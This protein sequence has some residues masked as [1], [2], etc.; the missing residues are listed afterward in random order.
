M[1]SSEQSSVLQACRRI[2][3]DTK[4]HDVCFTCSDGKRIGCNR[5]FVAASCEYFEKMLIDFNPVQ[6]GLIGEQQAVADIRLQAPSAA[7]SHVLHFLHTGSFASLASCAGDEDQEQHWLSLLETC[8]L[9]QLYMLPA[10]QQHIAE[11]L[12]QELPPHRLGL[13][14]SFAL[15]VRLACEQWH[16][17]SSRCNQ[18]YEGTH[19]MSCVSASAAKCCWWLCRAGSPLN[20]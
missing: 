5:S 3:L 4:F 12:M 19:T 16:S 13:A 20:G 2:L 7:V 18:C 8:S 9:A 6:G 14:L 11:Q 10:L 1:N 17:C 15:K